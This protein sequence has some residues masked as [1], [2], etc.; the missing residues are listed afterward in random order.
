MI[1][2]HHLEMASA[3]PLI[4]EALDAQLHLTPFQPRLLSERAAVTNH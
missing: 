4:R 2:I 3:T 1:T